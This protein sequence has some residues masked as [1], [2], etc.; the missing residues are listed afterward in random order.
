MSIDKH[1]LSAQRVRQ[2]TE[3]SGMSAM[4]VTAED[5]YAARVFGTTLY[6]TRIRDGIETDPEFIAW[7]SYKSAK[8]RLPFSHS[9]ANC[10]YHHGSDQHPRRCRKYALGGKCEGKCGKSH[11]ELPVQFIEG[12]GDLV[13][14][15]PGDV[16][17]LIASYCPTQ[18]KHLRVVC[19]RFHQVL[20]VEYLKTYP[21][22]TE[23]LTRYSRH[24]ELLSRC[25]TIITPVESRVRITDVSSLSGK[26][27]SY[28]DAIAYIH[29]HGDRIDDDFIYRAYRYNGLYVENVPIDIILAAVDRPSPRV[30]ILLT[31]VDN[32]IRI[33]EIHKYHTAGLASIIARRRFTWWGRPHVTELIHDPVRF[34][35]GDSYRACDYSNDTVYVISAS[36]LSRYSYGDQ[37][38]DIDPMYRSIARW[39]EDEYRW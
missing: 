38:S 8:C 25:R 35:I 12:L 14:G 20:R 13:T 4:A 11:E 9:R 15:L 17:R 32:I 27:S 23:L 7:S 1:R 39:T 33:V 21:G 26:I 29:E 3:L 5:S 2:K 28:M 36:R 30:T 37:Y 16:I 31:I 18:W 24:M 10:S 34:C 19:R 22:F 6:G